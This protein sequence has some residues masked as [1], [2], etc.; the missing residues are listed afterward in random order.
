MAAAFLL[1][2]GCGVPEPG[3]TGAGGD[4]VTNAGSTVT[5]G[6]N[7][8]G[9]GGDATG[10]SEL[11]GGAAGAGGPVVPDCE[12]SAACEST[13]DRPICDAANGVCV[14]CLPDGDQCADGEYCAVDGTC[15]TGC[16]ETA[17]CPTELICDPNTHLCVGCVIHDDCPT[18]TLCAEATSTCDPGCNSDHPCAGDE[19]CCAGMCADVEADPENCGACLQVC[20]DN[21]GTPSCAA[22]ECE[23]GCDEYFDDCD[24]DARSNGCETDL[25]ED[26]NCGECDLQCETTNADESTCTLDEEEDEYLCVPAC[27]TGYADDDDNPANGC[28]LNI[29]DCDADSCQN[30]GVCTDGVD[31]FTCDCSGTGYTGQFCETDVDECLAGTDDC[32]SN[33]TCTNTAG[34][35]TCTCPAGYLDVNGN[36][37]LCQPMGPPGYVGSTKTTGFCSNSCNLGSVSLAYTQQNSRTENPRR[38]ILLGVYCI[39]MNPADLPTF[40]SGSPTYGGVAMRQIALTAQSNHRVALYAVNETNLPPEDGQ[41]TALL[42]F[43][44]SAPYRGCTL[45]VVEIQNAQQGDLSTQAGRDAVFESILQQSPSQDCSNDQSVAAEVYSVTASADS[46]GYMLIGGTGQ[47]T[48]FTPKSGALTALFTN[49]S[50]SN[51]DGRASAGYAQNITGPTR[52]FAWTTSSCNSKSWVGAVLRP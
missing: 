14:A 34:S 29:D 33:A 31:S 28:E 38:M 39:G 7:T 35:F 19:R 44:N 45:N 42:T 17:D 16:S 47:N 43:T 30:G 20:S 48:G 24:E 12:T 27:T 9:R 26:A 4:A 5:G 15:Q 37:I 32:H 50:S 41:K 22:G 18:G 52:N 40:A 49:E 1:P 11:V 13:P 46:L 25:S 3:Y 2:A 6:V 8:G 23:I 36:G 21:H 10:G 51:T